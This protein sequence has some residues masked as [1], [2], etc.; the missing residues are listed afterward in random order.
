MKF[1]ASPTVNNPHG[2][3]VDWE[4]MTDQFF[5][6]Q[7]RALG[8]LLAWGASSVLS[9]ALLWS[10]RD[11]LLRQLGIQCLVWG[12]IDVALALAGRRSARHQAIRY[13]QGELDSTAVRHAARALQRILLINAGLDVGYVLAGGWLMHRFRQRRD[14]QGMGLGIALQGFFL[15]LYDSLV[16]L[17]L[18]RRW[19]AIERRM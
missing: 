3:I 2:A 4:N 13:H 12:A 6:Y 19:F 10:R 7:R 18:Q 15:F 5:G 17:D 14:R 1:Y 16:A 8:L 11:P 9:G